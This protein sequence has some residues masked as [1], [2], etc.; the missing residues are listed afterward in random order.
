M[1]STPNQRV[2]LDDLRQRLGNDDAVIAELFRM[3]LDDAPVHRAAI[4][5]AVQA[6]DVTGIRMAAHALRGAV[7]NLSAT[8]VVAAAAILERAAERG[9]TG[10]L[11]GYAANVDRET[12]LLLADLHERLS[13]E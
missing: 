12:E 3:F 1:F 2:D 6:R 7:S 5:D 9:E 8:G 4:A 10:D 11:E 13:T